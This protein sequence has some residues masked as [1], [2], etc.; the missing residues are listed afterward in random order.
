[1]LPYERWWVAGSNPVTR[2][3][4]KLTSSQGRTKSRPGMG[5]TSRLAEADS[6][7]PARKSEA[8]N[9]LFGPTL[10]AGGNNG[11]V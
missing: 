7:L 8:E 4:G 3:R 6:P 1:M 5:A 2:D 10:T 11:A 9:R